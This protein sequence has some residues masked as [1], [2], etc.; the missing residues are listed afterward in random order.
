VRK[1]NIVEKN[2]N[3]GFILLS[4]YTIIVLIRPHEWPMFDFQMPILRILL[5]FAFIS[6]LTSLKT[7]IWNEQAWLLLAFIFIMLLSEFRNFRLFNNYQVITGSLFNILL[8]F[9][10]YS[11]YINSHTRQKILL[12]ISVIS[13]L[14]MSLHSYY[15]INDINGEGWASTAIPRSDSDKLQ[16][17]Y[18]GVF[19]DPNDLGMFLVMNLPITVYLMNQS[20]GFMKKLFYLTSLIICLSCIYW[21]NSRGSLIG[22]FI[23]FFSFFYIKYGKGKSIM[24]GILTLPIA[25]F[26]LGKFRAIS[27]QDASSDSRIEAWYQGVL[28][29]KSHPIFGVGKGQF[30][31]HHIRT[32]HNSF[33]L[34]MSELGSLGYFIWVTFLLSILY[35]L[36]TILKLDI[37]KSL[38][39]ELFLKERQLALYLLVSIIGFCTTAFFISRAYILI[40]YIFAA[41]CTALFFRIAKIHPDLETKIPSSLLFKLFIISVL[42]LIFLYFIILSLL[43]I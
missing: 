43:N 14:I 13:C 16:A 33:V 12:I 24:L 17:R 30:I 42:S 10:L 11:A 4:L 1:N 25:I 9:L 5:I 28:M 21:T 34:V 39:K 38:D 40:F 36:T 41:M 26:I 37:D 23:V 20:N 31:E 3:F 19:N 22:A 32:A 29:F 15:Q 7:K 2:A 18:V 6:Y 35:M 8:P 27:A